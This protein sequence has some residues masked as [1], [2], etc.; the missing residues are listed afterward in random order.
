MEIKKL[1]NIS[2]I[3]EVTL[4]YDPIRSKHVVN[5]RMAS[6]AEANISFTDK[7]AAENEYNRLKDTFDNIEITD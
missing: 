6:G 4:S 3:E 2:M 1:I 5:I 7:D